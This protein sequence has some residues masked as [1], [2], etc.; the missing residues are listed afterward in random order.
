MRRYGARDRRAR[1]A[2]LIRGHEFRVVK[3]RQS[4]AAASLRGHPVRQGFFENTLQQV[5]HLDGAAGFQAFELAA[6]ND[7]AT[8]SN[9]A[10]WAASRFRASPSKA[11]LTPWCARRGASAPAMADC[12]NWRR[13]GCGT[14][15]SSVVR[16]RQEVAAGTA[17]AAPHAKSPA[18]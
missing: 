4:V 18:R 3:S 5:H 7:A 12:S 9:P 17:I 6:E 15:I 11:R 13:V 2:A 10:D 8:V 1:A 14:M 16:R